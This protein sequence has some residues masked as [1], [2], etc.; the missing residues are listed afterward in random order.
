MTPGFMVLA[1]PLGLTNNGQT[2]RKKKVGVVNHDSECPSLETPGVSS[3]RERTFVFRNVSFDPSSSVVLQGP[4]PGHR[5][6]A[7][8]PEG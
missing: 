4:L 6:A 8:R 7:R 5:S 1:R 2:T 3:I